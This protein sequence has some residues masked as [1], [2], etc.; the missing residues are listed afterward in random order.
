MSGRLSVT[1][2]LAIVCMGVRA[3][4]FEPLEGCFVATQA[5]KATP[6]I[7]GQGGP[8]AVTLEVGKSYRLL[9]ANKSDPTHY[10]IRVASPDQNRWIPVGCGSRAPT[11]EIAEGDHAGSGGGSAGEVRPAEY[12]LAV[13]WQPAFCES[14]PEKPECGSQT[15]E[16]FE[17]TNFTLHGLWP[18]PNGTFY[19]GVGEDVLDKDRPASWH[20]LPAVKLS[21]KTR[22]ALEE[23]MPGTRSFLDRHEWIKHGTCYGGSQEE[24]FSHSLHL[25]QELNASAVRELVAGRIGADVTLDELRAVFDKSFGKGAG[26]RVTMDCDRDGARQLV[27]ELL[28]SLAGELTES[29]ELSDLLEAAPPMPD[30]CRV[31]EIDAV[32]LAD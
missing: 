32:G 8:D 17:A 1:V 29:T 27:V 4:A 13:S 28:I 24:Y 18:Q 9:G 5:C 3:G 7:R 26:E 22:A 19:C 11:C 2:V 12:L 10:Q 15:G 20:R 6:R 14:R 16:S 25:L 23:M 21:P 31:G 30:D